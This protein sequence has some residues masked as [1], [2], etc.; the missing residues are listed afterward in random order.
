MDLK[1]IGLYIA[2]KRKALG[3]TQVQLAEKLG[4]SDK[5]VSKW[6]RG[7]CLPDVSVY[8]ELCSILGI[9]LNEFIAGQDLD[10]NHLIRQSEDNLLEV[11]KDSRRRI[12]G[13][14]KI[15]LALCLI[16]AILT[17]V[18]ISVLSIRLKQRNTISPFD[19]EST[20]MV[21][22][23]LFAGPDG[24]YIYRYATDSSYR[25]M[26]IY[27]TQYKGEKPINRE[28]YS[29][30]DL[31]GKGDKTGILGFVPDFDH[32]IV[33]IVNSSDGGKI[34]SELPILEGVK[35]RTYYG[36]S[37]AQIPGAMKI[38]PQKELPILA[39]YYG[40]DHIGMVPVEDLLNDRTPET[41]YTY[42]FTA[43]FSK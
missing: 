16:T 18:L 40:R 19:P 43:V 4:M 29:T 28:E 23:R 25:K 9:S 21:T 31:T 12:K 3:L 24:A 41:D 32:F 5:S 13:F 6:E 7:I 33:K 26:T 38:H 39:L 36:R 34:S 42:F 37:S 1:K 35:G 10:E 15:I 2:G 30:L 22:A 11:T 27:L 8:M 20:E 14:R 17:V